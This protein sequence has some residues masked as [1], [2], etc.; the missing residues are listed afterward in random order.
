MG[1]I[2]FQF[3]HWR[4]SCAA[5]VRFSHAGHAIRR[6]NSILNSDGGPNARGLVPYKCRYGS[7]FH[8]GHER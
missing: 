6:I 8:I 2:D 3:A 4:S 1:N 7:E 5:K